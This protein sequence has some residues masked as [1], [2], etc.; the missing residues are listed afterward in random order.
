MLDL[1]GLE[2]LSRLRVIDP[3]ACVIIMTGY[4]TEDA[5]AQALALGADA[6]L[7]KGFSLFELGE[8]LR[9]AIACMSKDPVLPAAVGSQSR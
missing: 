7:K 4:G 1:N 9:L 6:F 5:K 3:K 2:V 8:A